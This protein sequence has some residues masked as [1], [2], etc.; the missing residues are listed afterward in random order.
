MGRWFE[1]LTVTHEWLRGEQY[2]AHFIGQGERTKSKEEG[3]YLPS[4]DAAAPDLRVGQ[5]A[6]SKTQTVASSFDL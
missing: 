2:D 6:E 1:R 4:S 5:A 3:F